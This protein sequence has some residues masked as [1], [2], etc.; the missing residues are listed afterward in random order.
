MRTQVR[1]E[2]VGHADIAVACALRFLREDESQRRAGS[3]SACEFI[4]APRGIQGLTSCRLPP[5]A[6]HV[7]AS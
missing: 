5:E 1:G 4:V 6:R 7:Y 3:W 2:R